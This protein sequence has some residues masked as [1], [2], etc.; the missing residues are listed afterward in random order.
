MRLLASFMAGLVLFVSVSTDDK[1]YG[2]LG[3]LKIAKPE[4]KLDVSSTPAP[5]GAIVLFD[6]KSLDNW[7][8]TD[9]KSPAI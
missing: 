9:G 8:K 2:D 4:D 6:G 5:E 3:D 1:P 7:T